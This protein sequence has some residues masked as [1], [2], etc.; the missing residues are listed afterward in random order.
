M[1]LHA[2]ITVI[3][4]KVESEVGLLCLGSYSV[5]RAARIPL[6]LKLY[7]E[8]LTYPTSSDVGHTNS[9]M[10]EALEVISNSREIPVMMDEGVAY[11]GL[12]PYEDI[13]GRYFSCQDDPPLELVDCPA[14]SRVAGYN[15]PI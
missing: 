4:V 2:F 1:N 7:F 8:T 15:G 13:V 12:N 9:L 6:R 11:I 3:T 5:R 14:G 10:R